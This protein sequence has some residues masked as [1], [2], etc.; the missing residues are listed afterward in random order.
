MGKY[1]YK[2][3]VMRPVCFKNTKIVKI[4]TKC[5]PLTFKKIYDII[6]KKTIFF[7]AITLPS[8]IKIATKNLIKNLET[9]KCSFATKS[10]VKMSKFMV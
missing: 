2:K 8:S 9:I 5:A 6:L 1:Y 7:R 4:L 3:M 10:K